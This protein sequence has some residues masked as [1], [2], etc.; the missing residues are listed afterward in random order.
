MDYCSQKS[1]PNRVHITVGGNL[2][3]YPFKLTTCTADLTTS[4]IMWNSVVSTPGAKYACADAKNFYLCTP[5]DRYEYMRMP[6]DLIPPEFIEAYGLA[7]KVKNGY[8]YMEIQRRMYGLPQSGR[9]ANILLKER[10][11]EHGYY[12][13]PHTPGLFTHKTRPIWFTLVVDDF[14]IKYCERADID[15][16]LSVLKQFYDVE[17]DWTSGLYCGITLDWHYQEGYV[18]LSMPNYVQKQLVKYK[19]AKPKRPQFCPFEPNPINYG[20]KSD[21]IVPTPDSPKLDKKG[22]SSSNRSLEASS[23]TPEPSM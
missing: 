1:D 4:K 18:D 6:I 15:H 14:G 22:K 20:K 3:D 12:E 2:I 5:L 16:L 21:I 8:V 9:L 11:E 19:R 13:L 17:T 10:L 7:D 23:I